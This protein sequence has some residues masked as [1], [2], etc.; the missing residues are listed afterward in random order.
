VCTDDILRRA[1]A[2]NGRR[3]AA[4]LLGDQIGHQFVEAIG[5]VVGRP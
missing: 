2:D 1:L 3:R 5:G 4:E